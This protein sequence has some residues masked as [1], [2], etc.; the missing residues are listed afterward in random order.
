MRRFVLFIVV[1]LALASGL[2]VGATPRSAVAP[3]QLRLHRTAFDAHA[4]G[5]S[6]PTAALTA[7]RSYAIIQFHGPIGSADR[8]ALERTGVKLLEYMPDYAYL[9][10][11]DAAQLDA[12]ARLPQVYARRP[13]ILADK[14]APPLLRA[15]ARGDTTLTPLRI[16]A[17]PGAEDA[18]RRDLR[19]R[20]SVG[21]AVP[22]AEL[23]HIAGLE[24]VRW[25][26]PMSR[27]RLLNDVA[28]TIMRVDT[29]AWQ[30]QGLFGVNQIVAVA[31]SGLDT[32][33]IATMSPDFAGRIIA[34]HVLSAGGEL[35]DQHGH[36]THVAGSVAGAGVQSGA[37]PAQHQYA[38]S[39]AG[40]AP[41]AQL[42]IQAFEALPDGTTIGIPNDYYTLFQQA[43][44]DGAR[45]HTNSWG[46]HTGPIADTEASFGGYPSGAQRTD[47]FIWD[48][49]DLAVFFAAGN[50]GADGTPGALGFC[51]GGNGIVDPDSLLSPGTAKNVVTVGAAETQR[52]SGGASQTPWLL[53]SFCFATPPIA[54]DLVSNNPNGMAAFSS[55]GP[56]DDGRAKP[57][58]V[59]PGTDIISNRSHYPNA[60]TLW[61]PH[62][63]HYSYSGGTSMA[64]PLAAGAGA[65]VREWL[66]ARGI[67]NPSA[68]AVKAALLSTSHDMAP[69][70]YGTGATQEIPDTLPS[71]VAGWGRVDLG[72]MDAPAPYALWVDDHTT[73]ISTGHQV[74]YAD[75]AARPLEVR[76]SS[77]PL[78]VMLAWTDPPASL[79]AARQLVNDLDLRV[80][81]PGGTV[82]HGNNVA[83]G[84][85][86]NNIEGIVIDTPPVGHY[87]VEVRGFNVPIATQ[88]YA[89]AVARSYAAA[90]QMTLTKT[91]NPASYVQPSG[92]ITY[93]LQARAQGG[94]L[95]SVV[96]S[97]TLPANTTF[98]S[99][100][101]VYTRSGPNN[102]VI[103]WSVGSL[104][105]GQTIARTLIV[106]V[107]PNASIG[108]TISNTSYSVSAAG[109]APISHP[110][111]NVTLQEP[112]PPKRMWIPLIA[113]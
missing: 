84:D 81:G 18:L 54:T 77:Q 99:A 28:R 45:I 82:Y 3:P 7:T 5:R 51:T 71:S 102:S 107:S 53:L 46:D 76:D 66:V 27:P 49:P 25:I 32:G 94:P 22:T 1:M 11:G 52:A 9:V 87:S 70:Q 80:I 56:T 41:E 72:F 104:A 50:S 86:I 57:D 96:L 103:A 35:G 59:V 37:T 48:H 113:R 89:L 69:G 23:L 58:I 88:P 105:A 34:T 16:V 63:D 112:P 74:S 14:L 98:V 30:G 38:G 39:F 10:R 13:F 47:Q 83:T 109:V 93:T 21:A 44:A 20:H 12:A 24:S 62:N 2:S 68:A 75:T 40:V 79:S 19:A 106:R 60:G 91:A 42:V 29:A 4:A 110:P 33:V 67:A 97:D 111:V 55:R 92:L 61:G 95:S 101:G 36:G 6:V 73:G 65:L 8:A 15:L 64:T 17:W 43:Y 26:E 31:D 78:R 90:G 108:D 100:S 85:R